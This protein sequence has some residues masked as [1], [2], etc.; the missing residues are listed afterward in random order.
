MNLKSKKEVDIVT[1]DAVNSLKEKLHKKN[2]M[3]KNGL[4]FDEALARTNIQNFIE[5]MGHIKVFSFFPIEIMSTK[6]VSD[7][8]VNNILSR[9]DS[10]K[11][12][13]KDEGDKANIE[14]QDESDS[15]KESGSRQ[16]M[17]DLKTGKYHLLRKNRVID[18]FIVGDLVQLDDVFGTEYIGNVPDYWC[19][20]IKIHLCIYLRNTKFFTDN[21]VQFNTV[22]SNVISEVKEDFNYFYTALLE[23]VNVAQ[24]KSFQV[25][26]CLLQIHSSIIDYV[27][28]M[29]KLTI[30][31]CV[32]V[33]DRVRNDDKK[34]VI[35]RLKQWAINLQNIFI[36]SINDCRNKSI[37]KYKAAPGVPSINELSL[38]FA[39]YLH[40]IAENDFRQKEVENLSKN[41]SE[42]EM[43]VCNALTVAEL[44]DKNKYS[45]YLT[46]DPNKKASE[47]KI[48]Q[49]KWLARRY[50]VDSNAP[51]FPYTVKP[52]YRALFTRKVSPTSKAMKN[53]LLEIENN[54]SNPNDIVEFY[55][56][57]DRQH[58]RHL[59]TLGLYSDFNA[60]L[61]EIYKVTGETYRTLNTEDALHIL[62]DFFNKYL[63]FFTNEKISG[64]T[65]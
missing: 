45:E 7:F 65:F 52:F 64:M 2:D 48:E 19:E 60:V 22:V 13:I 15:S 46:E 51:E 54:T 20:E 10:Y 57:L 28:E 24:E 44:S 16:I 37:K 25:M 5:N 34:T 59:E 50:S 18:S 26:F 56:E 38:Q 1:E 47:K 3:L 42:K 27:E 43:N 36:S 12:I 53:I 11:G 23:N 4:L 32:I 21:Q 9:N 14:N 30:Y 61:F 17:D 49:A 40:K 29:I 6:M 39:F 31:F 63:E 41:N 33:N 62:F 55:Q 8:I 35:S 58:H